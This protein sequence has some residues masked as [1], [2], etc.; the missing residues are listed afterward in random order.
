MEFLHL[1]QAPL[2]CSS[3][4]CS[5]GNI[6]RHLAESVGQ[7]LSFRVKTTRLKFL[8]QVK[9]LCFLTEK[10]HEALPGPA[11]KLLIYGYNNA[12]SLHNGHCTCNFLQHFK[13]ANPEFKHKI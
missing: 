11:Y 9:R 1:N 10:V 2:H 7:N 3:K 8:S 13:K 4:R 5:E 12:K 6:S